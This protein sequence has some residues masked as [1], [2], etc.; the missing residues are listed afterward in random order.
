MFALVLT[1]VTCTKL[2]G[3]KYSFKTGMIYSAS[4]EI[5]FDEKHF[6]AFLKK[7]D[8]QARRGFF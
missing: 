7:S 6:K 8:Y 5:E 2:I 3:L 4:N 1:F